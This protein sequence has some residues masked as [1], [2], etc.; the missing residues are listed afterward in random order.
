MQ[1]SHIEHVGIAVTSLEEAIPFY[2]RNLHNCLN[3][4]SYFKEYYKCLSF[5]LQNY[6]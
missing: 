6:K 4:K 3:L 2:V 1:I 5:K